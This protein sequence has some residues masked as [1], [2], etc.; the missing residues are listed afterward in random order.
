MCIIKKL[1][2]SQSLV[3]AAAELGYHPLAGMG[4]NPQMSE[5]SC[6]FP[7]LERVPSIKK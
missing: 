3:G 4:V 1:V 2:A 5:L 7:Y 6:R